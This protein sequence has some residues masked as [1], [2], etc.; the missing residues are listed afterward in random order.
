MLILGCKVMIASRKL[1][2]LSASAEI[3]RGQITNKSARLEH[4]QCNIR[5]EDQVKHSLHLFTLHKEF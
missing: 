2:R 1:D 5:Q 3:L 4:M